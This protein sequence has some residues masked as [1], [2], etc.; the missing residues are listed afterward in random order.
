MILEEWAT[1]PLET[2]HELYAFLGVDPSF[3]PSADVLHNVGGLPRSRLLDSVLGSRRLRALV[4]P[5]VP[6]GLRNAIVRL[7]GRNLARPPPL[8]ADLRRR[9]L[10]VYRE[11]W[12]RLEELLGRSLDVWR[13]SE[14]DAG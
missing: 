9:L 6:L 7:R 10:E 11:D 13:E 14:P 3:T 8:P 2:I 1:N 4:A 5:I 12:E